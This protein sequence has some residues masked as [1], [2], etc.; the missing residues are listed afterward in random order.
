MREVV[1]IK[2]N[3][4]KWKRFENMLQSQ[5]RSNPDEM[6]SLYIQLIDDLSYAR[7]FYSSSPICTCL[8]DLSG[9]GSHCNL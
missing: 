1:F 3:T 5:D 2:Q 9:Q 6:A 7:T 8:N 4:E